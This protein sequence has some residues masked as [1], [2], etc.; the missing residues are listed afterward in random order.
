MRG[1]YAQGHIFFIL[2]KISPSAT[3]DECSPL[4]LIGITIILFVR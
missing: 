4:L 1:A 3:S 2:E